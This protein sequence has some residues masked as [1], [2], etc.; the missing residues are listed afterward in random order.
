MLIL[1][2]AP[3]GSS[4]TAVAH[5]TSTQKTGRFTHFASATD[6]SAVTVTWDE[7][8][9]PLAGTVVERNHGTGLPNDIPGGLIVPSEGCWELTFSLGNKSYGPFG[10]NITSR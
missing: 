9:D 4:I 2:D 7:A 1:T 5:Q 10:I 8:Q 6:E 3:A